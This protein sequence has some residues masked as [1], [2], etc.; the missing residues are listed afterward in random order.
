MSTNFLKHCKL[1]ELEML[2]EIILGNLEDTEKEEFLEEIRKELIPKLNEARITNEFSSGRMPHYQKELEIPCGNILEQIG[3]NELCFFVRSFMEKGNAVDIRCVSYGE[4]FD[5]QSNYHINIYFIFR[6]SNYGI[7]PYSLLTDGSLKQLD[8]VFTNTDYI[9]NYEA[10][11]HTFCYIKDSI[12]SYL[13][14]YKEEA[15]KEHFFRDYPEKQELV[16]T[17]LQDIAKYLYEVREEN[18]LRMSITNQGL[19]RT[20]RKV[21]DGI[22]YHQQRMVEA[23]AFG[24]TIEKLEAKNYEDSKRLLYRS[25]S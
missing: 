1:E 6:K 25:G 17:Q 21:G 5:F 24:T 14:Q 4:P 10:V 8:E 15:S 2:K 11:Y 16:K 20:A 12:Y 22:T 9:D 3:V 13:S 19:R 23:I 18:G 7:N